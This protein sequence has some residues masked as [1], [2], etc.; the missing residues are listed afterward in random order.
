MTRPRGRLFARPLVEGLEDRCLLAAVQFSQFPIPTPSANPTSIVVGAD[1]NLW[2]TELGFSGAPTKIGRSTPSGVI[3]EFAIPSGGILLSIISGP[4]GNIWFT[5]E[6]LPFNSNVPDRV[7]RITPAGT[8]TEF[9]LPPSPT[10][11]KVASDIT[12]GPDGNLWVG[13]VGPNRTGPPTVARI[14]PS[15]T[16]TE[17]QLALASNN[18]PVGSITT[19]PDGNLWVLAGASADAFTPMGTVVKELP[20]TSNWLKMLFDADGNLWTAQYGYPPHG[21]AVRITPSGNVTNFDFPDST[22]P[23]SLPG[24]VFTVGPDGNLWYAVSNGLVPAGHILR[25][26]PRGNVTDFNLPSGVLPAAIMAG[27]DGALWFTANKSVAIGYTLGRITVTGAINL[28]AVPNYTPAVGMSGLITGP[29]GNLWYLDNDQNEVVRINLN[30]VN[31]LGGPNGRYVT[32]LYQVLLDRVADPQG[33]S[34]FTTLLNDAQVT[35]THAA[36]T[37]LS[38]QEYQTDEVTQLY[39]ATLHRNPDPAGL[40]SFVSFLA[41]GNSP[42]QAEATMLGSAEYFNNA[43]GTNPGFVT[44]LYETVLGRQSD[45]AGAANVMQELAKGVSRRMAA[46][47]VLTSPEGISVEVQHLYQTLLG[48]AADPTGLAGGITLIENT[49]SPLPLVLKLVT[50]AEFIDG[51]NGNTNQLFVEQIYQALLGRAA[52]PAGLA[53]VTGVLDAGTMNR[54]QVVAAIER[55]P[56]FLTDEVENLYQQVLGRPADASGMG[57][58]L[59]FLESGGTGSQL[60]TILLSSNEFFRAA[61]GGTNSGFLSALYQVVL[62][63][64]IDSSGAQSCGQALSA[65]ASRASVVGDVL[66]S[67]ESETLEV[68][69]LY[70][71]YLGR[72]ADPGGLDSTLAVLQQGGSL[73]Q[74]AALLMASPEYLS[75]L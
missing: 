33:L 41:A 55:S 13:V 18:G 65:G 29:D 34:G 39:Q 72:Q 45:A 74:L 5:E 1:G 60:E 23:Q 73:E 25:I 10:G 67:T 21:A 6:V 52:D 37:I 70:N 31:T 17:S 71:R 14:T 64:A 56:E 35:Q 20:T 43:G 11:D 15:G 46:Q 69:G 38:C 47:Q 49:G 50:S 62:N 26:T 7:G 28:Y 59:G 66:Y 51:V 42:T 44:A 3:T 4:D 16:I 53:A 32:Q 27:P 19:G 2:F 22:V 12:V 58:W 30:A 40:S 54:M 48:R 61:G 36:Q 9:A 75:R 57:T 68:E 8:I 63:R 24:A